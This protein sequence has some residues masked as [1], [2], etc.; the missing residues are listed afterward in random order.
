MI[1]T[2]VRGAAVCLA[3]AGL[4]TCRLQPELETTTG[5]TTSMDER[6]LRRWRLVFLFLD[7]NDLA[8]TVDVA[9]HRIAATPEGRD[10]SYRIILRDSRY[11]GSAVE[12]VRQGE[13]ARIPLAELPVGSLLSGEVLGRVLTVLHRE[14][15]AEEQILVVSGHGRGWR[16]LGATAGAP[17]AVLSGAS[18]AE[19]L[20][21]LPAEVGQ[22]LVLEAGWSGFV[23]N[24]YS[25][26]DL[27][28]AVIAAVTDVRRTGMD[29]PWWLQQADHA[30]WDR[31]AIADF[32]VQAMRE[33]QLTPEEPLW[34]HAEDLETLPLVID[35]VI[36]EHG[37]LP[38]GPDLQQQVQQDLLGRAQ[39]P[40]LPGEA[41]I[42]LRDLD[43]LVPEQFRN[44]LLHLVLVD[45]HGGAVGHAREYRQESA[46]REHP[47]LTSQAWAPDLLNRRG[48]LFDLWYRTW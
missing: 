27:P 10:E 21:A 47:F 46:S 2:V 42:A 40:V 48:F 20:D 31:E 7:D 34:L 35:G 5:T 14:F 1:G 32:L 3:L 11:D 23:E 4:L 13:L 22:I 6:E 25:L 15:P 8:G 38:I 24:L 39:T 12:V 30:G 28:V 9:A 18:L 16:G 36:R 33:A 45:E 17:M 41:H 37:I 26:K 44:L 29:H 19:A 43:P